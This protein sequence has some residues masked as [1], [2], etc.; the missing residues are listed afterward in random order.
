[1]SDIITSF[2]LPVGLTDYEVIQNFCEDM[3][4]E[5]VVDRK[6]AA[7]QVMALEG[8]HK[9]NIKPDD[10]IYI[11]S[12]VSLIS[13]PGIDGEGEVLCI[14]GESPSISEF[15][16][17]ATNMIND[18]QTTVFSYEDEEDN[19]IYFPICYDYTGDHDLDVLTVKLRKYLTDDMLKFSEVKTNYFT[20][21]EFVLSLDGYVEN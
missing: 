14:T 19:L 2:S 5:N 9:M 11:L 12:D 21:E 17:N 16:F 3:N 20:M 18:E 15:L 6:F 7:I 4:I 8:Y 1:M 10:T 13:I